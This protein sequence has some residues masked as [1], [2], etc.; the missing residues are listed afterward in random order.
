[1]MNNSGNNILNSD[2]FSGFRQDLKLELDILNVDKPEEKAPLL[3]EL[4][5][6]ELFR[7]NYDKA[8]KHI[9]EAQKLF[10]ELKDINKIAICLT[11]LA[12]IHYKKCN[13]RLI[14]ALT[15]LNDAKY[16]IAN[17]ESKNEVEAKI[18]HYYGIINYSEKRYS[19]A[20]KYFKNAQNL[21]SIENIEY[22]NILDSLAIF[23][24]RV[25]NNQ[26]ALQCLNESLKIKK[27][28]N[29]TREIAITEILFGRYLSGIENYE[30]AVNYLKEAL[31]ISEMHC[32]YFT[33]ARLLDEMAKIYIN[34]EDHSLA[35]KLCVKSVKIAKEIDSPLIYAFS[36]CTIA[37]IKYSKW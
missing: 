30:E 13:D 33:V 29:M 9:E 26:I 31:L 5:S 36:S 4:G 2:D 22:A 17:Q 23:Y 25:N 34:L 8:I 20:L 35:E 27:T 18:L 6:T 28:L 14:R 11:E 37:D 15:L 21:V 7:K 12:M 16:L 1:M 10:L 19:E 3:L 32:D 24:M